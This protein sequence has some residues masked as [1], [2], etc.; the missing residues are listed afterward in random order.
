MNFSVISPPMSSNMLQALLGFH[1]RG[2]NACCHDSLRKC[3]EFAQ[4]PLG[5]SG[6]IKTTGAVNLRSDPNF[7]PP[8]SN[9]GSGHTG[10]W[11]LTPKS[12]AS[13]TLYMPNQLLDP[14]EYALTAIVFDK[15]GSANP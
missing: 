8:I 5:L 6:L 2:N 15:F 12:R 13:I 9:E 3:H 10:N 14:V 11:A 1:L 7:Q 4:T